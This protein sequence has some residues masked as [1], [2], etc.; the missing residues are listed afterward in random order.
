MGHRYSN[1]WTMYGNENI[2]F[3]LFMSALEVHDKL[4]GLAVEKNLEVELK[5]LQTF[6]TIEILIQTLN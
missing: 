2:S 4:T 6:Q 3:F 5:T 1:V